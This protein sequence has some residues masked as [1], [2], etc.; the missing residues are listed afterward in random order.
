MKPHRLIY[1]LKSVP[2][3]LAADSF[4]QFGTYQRFTGG[5]EPRASL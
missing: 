4:E 1:T 5:A 3:V 2:L